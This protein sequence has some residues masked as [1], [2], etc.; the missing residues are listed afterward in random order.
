MEC[1]CCGTQINLDEDCSVCGFPAISVIGDEAS[2]KKKIMEEAEK[3][4][5]EILRNYDIG[6]ITYLGQERKRVSIA[7]ANELVYQDKWLEQKI[8]RIDGKK[9]IMVD[10][11][12]LKNG[13][14]EQ[15][16]S[17]ELPVLKEVDFW[18]VGLSLKKGFQLKLMIK[19]DSSK[20]ES[21]SIRFVTR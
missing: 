10:L 16:Y 14:Q 6:I 15:I 18:K 17:L 8:A 2:A 13:G 12:V 20:V 5:N 9:K 19:N 3:Y 7:G 1:Y 4:R 11:S 21:E